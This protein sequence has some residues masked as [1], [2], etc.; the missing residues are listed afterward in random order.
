MMYLNKGGEDMEH[1]IEGI[2]ELLFGLVKKSPEKRPD[3]E[4]KNKF[5]VCHN[6]VSSVIILTLLF[7]GSVLF[8]ALSFFMVD[9]TRILFYIFS[10]LFVILFILF[11]F[12]FSIKCDVT[13]EGIQKTTLFFFKKEILWD[14]VFCVRVMEKDDESDI[15][16]ALYNYEKNCILDIS[17][18]MENAWFIVKMAEIKNIE[19]REEK[20]LTIK[21]IR[22]L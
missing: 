7:L 22:K 12:M 14:S 2:L 20:N 15:M 8:L 9:D 4:L 16:I 11:I 21:Q 10:S 5:T 18:N 13:L 3:I 17:T 6:K 19:I 1:F